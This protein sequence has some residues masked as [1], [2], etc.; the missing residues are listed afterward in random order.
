[1]LN[2][3]KIQ[4]SPTNVFGLMATPAVPCM[5]GGQISKPRLKAVPKAVNVAIG[6]HTLT[7]MSV[8]CEYWP[9][10]DTDHDYGYGYEAVY[11][12]KQISLADA[13]QWVRAQLA[14]QGVNVAQF[15]NQDE[16]TETVDAIAAPIRAEAEQILTQCCQRRP[17]RDPATG[18]LLS[19][20][21]DTD[22]TFRDR[23]V[24]V[25][26]HG[27]D[28][29]HRDAMRRTWPRTVQDGEPATESGPATTPAAG[30]IAQLKA[31]AD[32]ANKAGL[33]SPA[34]DAFNA[35]VI[36]LVSKSS[37]PEA[38]IGELA[39]LLHRE[40]IRTTNCRLFPAW[41]VETGP[42]YDHVS[43]DVKVIDAEGEDVVDA[44]IL[45]LSDTSPIVCIGQSDFTAD[46][47]RMKAAELRGFADRIDELSG[48]VDKAHA[49][50]A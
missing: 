13:E 48:H 35:K 30:I 43:A 11:D 22:E 2:T 38:T 26:R 44:R 46:E 23:L 32:A 50:R 21:E 27:H 42:H 3:D 16:H 47:A 9:A 24:C 18:D 6:H 34:L 15:I 39:Q 4:A 37:N 45:Y 36:R 8:P 28:G 1:M 5:L 31:N 20:V 25:E 40:P 14:E 17:D 12:P 49:P 7:S 19:G 41:C 29:D 10:T 33:G